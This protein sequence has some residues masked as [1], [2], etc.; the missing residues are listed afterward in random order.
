MPKFFV[1]IFT[2]VYPLVSLTRELGNYCVRWMARVECTRKILS[3]DHLQAFK[4]REKL[5][6]S[7][8]MV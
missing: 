7:M 6:L 5:R 1:G 3:A 2:E 8:Y 4:N